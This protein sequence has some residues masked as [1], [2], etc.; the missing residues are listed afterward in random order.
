MPIRR[1]CLITIL[2]VCI[3]GQ[4]ENTLC[5]GCL[6]GERQPSDPISPAV[7]SLSSTCRQ[8]IDI[9][10]LPSLL[11]DR[12]SRNVTGK[13]VL[14]EMQRHLARLRADPS[15]GGGS[16]SSN[17]E[18]GKPPH[19]MF[20]RI[21]LTVITMLNRDASSRSHLSS[22]GAFEA[23]A[24][25]VSLFCR[26][27]EGIRKRTKGTHWDLREEPSARHTGGRYCNLR[28]LWDCIWAQRRA[29]DCVSLGA[30][31]GPQRF[32]LNG[33]GWVFQC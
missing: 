32:K 20:K 17:D 23:V 18:A 19:A 28:G 3:N 4:P 10:K 29:W 15:L 11:P 27:V 2:L 12:R 22:S 5:W 14:F 16:D 13:M 25:S 8:G 1:P 7:R 33:I 26:H 24:G 21:Q 30:Y 6:L 9:R 31:N